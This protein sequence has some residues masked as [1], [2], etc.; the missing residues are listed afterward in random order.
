MGFGGVFIRAENTEDLALWYR[1]N[2]GIDLQDDWPGG[3]FPLRHPDDPGGSYVVWSVYADKPDE[4][5]QPVGP[6]TLNFRVRNLEAMLSQLRANGIEV[7]E[8]E[9]SE[10]GVF[11]RL[12]DPEGNP[13]ELWQPPANLPPDWR[14]PEPH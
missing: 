14:D 9:Q 5:G 2:L 11:A 4:S 8:G 13:I 12:A 1:D 10:Y 3:L 7:T 6:F